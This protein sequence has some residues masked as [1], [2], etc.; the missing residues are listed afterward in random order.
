M[1]NFSTNHTKSDLTCPTIVKY[2][3]FIEDLQFF[4]F[5]DLAMS[6]YNDTIA[7][8]QK[9]RV[10][11]ADIETV[12][13]YMWHVLEYPEMNIVSKVKDFISISSCLIPIFLPFQDF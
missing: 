10:L 9:K 7:D 11:P 2:Q 3:D 5:S 6:I 1:F 4:G 8:L 13:G 12:S